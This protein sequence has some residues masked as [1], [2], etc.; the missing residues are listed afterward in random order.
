MRSPARTKGPGPA[1]LYAMLLALLWQALAAQ[2]HRHL[3]LPLASAQVSVSARGV[4]DSQPGAPLDSAAGCSFCRE[5][6]HAGPL[7]LP[8]A[9][10]IEV[11]AETA[12][13]ITPTRLHALDLLAR[14]PLWRSRAPPPLQA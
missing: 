9:I 7:L 3:D 4:G 10:S 2:V 12:F 13:R 8:A 14:A 1:L 11:P 5:L 6:A